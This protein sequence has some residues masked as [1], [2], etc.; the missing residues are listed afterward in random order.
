MWSLTATSLLECS[1]YLIE[2]RLCFPVNTLYLTHSLTFS[3]TPSLPHTLSLSHS[4]THSLTHSFTHSHITLT[5]PLMQYPLYSI[6]DF[7]GICTQPLTL[8]LTHYLTLSL[9]HSLIYS[10]TPSLSHLLTSAMQPARY[11]CCT[12][13]S[14]TELHCNVAHGNRMACWFPMLRRP[15]TCTHAPWVIIT[16][17]ATPTNS[18]LSVSVSMSASPGGCSHT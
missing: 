11:I 13:L 10:L 9:S 4:L 3:H 12:A 18:A 6:K 1:E 2:F 5:Q 7:C 8:S 14:C 17:C 15:C 16:L